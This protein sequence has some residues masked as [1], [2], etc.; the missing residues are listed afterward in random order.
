MGTPDFAV[1]ALK[2]LAEYN[3]HISLVITQPDRPKG[4][5]KKII[6]PPVK[7]A[8]EELGLEIIQPKSMKGEKIREKL[9]E[10]KPD[11]FVVV[12][13]GHKLS[14]EILSIP[15]IFPINIHASLL[16]E[17]RGSSPIQAAILNMD[18]KAGVTTMV[19]DD[20]LDTGDILLKAETPIK[21]D[22]TASDLHDTLA[23]MGAE[24]I[25]KTLDAIYDDKITPYPQDNDKATFAPMLKKNDGK[26]DWE[27]SPDEINAL[28]RAMNPWPGTFTFLNGKR[29][30]IL[31]VSCSNSNK[32]KNSKLKSK[33]KSKSNKSSNKNRSE[34]EIS[35]PVKN[36]TP[37][38]ESIAPGTVIL[39]DSSGI[40]VAAGNS[41]Y[42]SILEIQAEGGKRLRACEFLRGRNLETGIRFD[43]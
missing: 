29:I 3:C 37:P 27:K 31:R 28:V 11:I 17:Y 35:V 24:L 20:S 38:I 32:N 16:P 7:T 41:G 12:A 39:C 4:R 36:I 19:M 42:V 26:I 18:K 40:R 33:S 9:A 34:D 30:K 8:A 5:G 43:Y 1:P 21:C 2:A 6:A 10:L 14:R 25:I 13:F 22:T 15:S 23:Q